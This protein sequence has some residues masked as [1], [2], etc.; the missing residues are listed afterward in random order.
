M[1]SDSLAAESV[2]AGGDFASNRDAAP[3]GVKGANSTLA[4]TDTS[5]A[6]TLEA[7][8]DRPSRGEE[9]LDERVKYPEGAG[10]QGGGHGGSWKAGDVGGSEGG[11]KEE[12]GKG[13]TGGEGG[14]ARGGKGVE[15][16]MASTGGDA[17]GVDTKRGEGKAGG[18][19][20]S[21]G[22]EKG[23]QHVDTAPSYVH[24]GQAAGGKPKGKNL[25]EGGFDDDDGKNA[26][27]T[28][29]IG[30]ENDPGRLAED[31]FEQE[32][33]ESAAYVGG[34]PRQKKITG[35]GQYASLEDDQQL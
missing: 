34:G 7:A 22:G 2:R 24:G 15:K 17:G 18:T 28:S 16:S 25:T 35:N 8:P 10:G 1:A 27:F 3:M 13:L 5:G 30:D 4:N 14:V 26:S 31:K 9:G 23:A 12:S 11:M 33:A 19:G 6:V 20:D 32:N 29:N 21:V